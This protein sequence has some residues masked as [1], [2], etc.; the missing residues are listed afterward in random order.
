MANLFDSTVYARLYR[1]RIHLRDLASGT[2]FTAQA[3]PP[4]STARLLVGEFLPFE[5]CLKEG[6]AQVVGKRFFTPRPVL[7]LQPMEMNEGGLSGIEQRVLQ[8]GGLGAGARQVILHEGAVL[9]DAAAR[10][11]LR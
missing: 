9:D 7:I 3:S 6:L 5:Q 1:N 2:E 4:F 8:E 10:R 11:L